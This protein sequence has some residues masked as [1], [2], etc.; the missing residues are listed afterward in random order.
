MFL[1]VLCVFVMRIKVL[2]FFLNK[3]PARNALLAEFLAKL[4]QCLQQVADQIQAAAF[5][6]IEIHH[7]PRREGAGEVG[8][9]A[10]AECYNE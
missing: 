6:I 9:S 3:K 10:W 4:R 8:R 5:L 7:V 1:R 2:V